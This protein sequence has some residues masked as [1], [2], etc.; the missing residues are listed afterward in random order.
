[1]SVKELRELTQAGFLDC[2]KALEESGN[3]MKLAIELLRKK[4]LSKANKRSGVEAMDGAV[5]IR[6]SGNKYGMLFFGTETDFVAKN[7]QFAKFADD[8]LA[9]FLES[10]LDDIKQ[11][12]RDETF[13]NRLAYLASKIGENIVLK[14][15]FKI[16][17]QSGEMVTSY[18]HNKLNDKFENIAKIGVLLKTKGA[19]IEQAKQLAMHIASFKPVALS[20]AKMNAEQK[21]LI[22]EE[23]KLKDLVLD[24]QPFLIDPS[25]NISQFCKKNNIEII[26]FKV[27]S[28]K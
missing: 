9:A 13:A 8:E 4:G 28:V 25:M 1:M 10:K 27:F 19:S 12:E 5:V 21:A 24:L 22:S 26:E 23:K 7:D 2:K 18:L 16:T 14:D 11:L 17:E 6:K 15:Q 20:E 3:N